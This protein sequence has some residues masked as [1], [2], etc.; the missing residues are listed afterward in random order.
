MNF[1]RFLRRIGTPAAI[2]SSLRPLL[3]WPFLL[4]AAVI[5]ALTLAGMR[6]T[7]HQQKDKEIARFQAIADLKVSQ[8]AAWFEERHGDA[9]LLHGS[10]FLADLYQRWRSAGDPA[11]RD[12]RS[13]IRDPRSAIRDPRSASSCASGWMSTGRLIATRTRSCSTSRVNRR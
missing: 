6:Y 3:T 5:V 1:K 7:F 8:I 9:Q 2:G 4:L 13:A 11:I 12:P 10:R